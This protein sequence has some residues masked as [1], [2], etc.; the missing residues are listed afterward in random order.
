MPKKKC[1]THHY[2]LES[3]IGKTA[4]GVCKLCGHTKTH[5]NSNDRP[6]AKRVTNKGRVP[7]DVVGIV[8]SGKERSPHFNP[9][10]TDYNEKQPKPHFANGFRGGWNA[11]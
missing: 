4:E 2:I 3:P 9:S 10:S 1:T 11:K 6:V 8:L 5:Y 7:Q